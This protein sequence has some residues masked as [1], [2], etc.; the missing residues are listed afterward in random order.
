MLQVTTQEELMAQVAAEIKEQQRQR[1][2]AVETYTTAADAIWALL[3]RGGGGAAAA[4]PT[5][6]LPAATTLLRFYH[7]DAANA[8]PAPQLSREVALLLDPA[9]RTAIAAHLTDLHERAATKAGPFIA[10]LPPGAL[11]E[12]VTPEMLPGG[13]TC[14]LLANAD[15]SLVAG[16]A[17]APA[18]EVPGLPG[19]GPLN[20]QTLAFGLAVVEKQVKELERGTLVCCLQS[21]WR[22]SIRLVRQRGSTAPLPAV[23]HTAAGHVPGALPCSHPIDRAGAGPAPAVP[24]DAGRGRRALCGLQRVRAGAV[25]GACACAPH[26]AP[27]GG[28]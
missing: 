13:R 6:L 16:M 10:A 23:M 15:G 9:A 4:V 20:L 26:V 3:E 7:A 18:G 2:E 8:G 5:P 25:P 22:G 27:A 21:A 14:R 17:A 24:A 19:K 28:E 1:Q 12:G 11:G